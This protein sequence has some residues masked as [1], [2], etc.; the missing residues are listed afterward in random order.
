MRSGCRLWRLQPSRLRKD[1]GEGAEE[2]E[3]RVSPTLQRPLANSHSGGARLDSR[4]FLG[5]FCDNIF[6]LQLL[7]CLTTMMLAKKDETWCVSLCHTLCEMR[8]SSSFSDVIIQAD[9][10]NVLKAH[11]C[12]L[13]AASPVLKTQLL[14][15]QHYLYIPKISKCMWEVLLQFIYTGNLE[16]PQPS[17]IPGILKAGKRLQLTRLT[18]LCEDL[19]KDKGGKDKCAQVKEPRNIIVETETSQAEFDDGMY[20]GW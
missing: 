18:S 12:V 20:T 11:T 17:E 13:A 15:S 10:D 7:F 5:I 3:V 9:G 2:I 6:T 4:L 14:L 8:Q 16:I 19:L 1:S